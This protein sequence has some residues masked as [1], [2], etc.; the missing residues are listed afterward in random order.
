MFDYSKEKMYNEDDEGEFRFSN[1]YA[2]L[3]NHLKKFMT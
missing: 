1:S 3:I 2:V